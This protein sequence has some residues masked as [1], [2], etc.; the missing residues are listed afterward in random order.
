M[1]HGAPSGQEGETSEPTSVSETS[2]APDN[3]Q[4]VLDYYAAHP[5]FFIFATPADVPG[6]LAWENGSDLPEIGS[7]DAKKGGTW[8]ARIQ[9]FPRTLRLM[10][11]DSNG[12][13]RGYILDDVRMYFGHA[14]PQPG[15]DEFLGYPGLAKEWAVDKDSSTVFVRID[16]DARFNDGEPVTTEDVMFSFFMFRSSYVVSPWL[17]DYY[18]TTFSKVTQYD[19]HTFSLTFPQTKPDMVSKALGWVPM[20][21]HFFKELGEDF[22][23]RYQWKFVPTTGPYV[24]H[25]EDLKKGRSVV[26]RRDD[27]WWAKDKKFWR[28]RYN[29]DALRLVVIRDTPKAFEAF[30]RGDL[31]DTS[32]NLAEYWYDKLPDTDDAVAKGY[33]EKAWFYN[34]RPRPTYGL[35]V[36]SHKPVLDDQNIRLGLQHATNFQQV[37]DK[38]Y[39]GDVT[40]MKSRTDGYGPVSHPTI[41]ARA[42]DVEKAKEYFA[43]AGYTEVG[44]DGVLMNAEGKRLSFTLST[45]YEALKDILAI[46]REEGMKAGV[47][48]RLEVL[49]GTT[50]WKKFQEKKHDIHLAAFGVGY[51]PYPRHFEFLHSYNAYENAFLEDGSVNPDRKV[52]TQTNNNRMV[53]N[54]ELDQLV[55]RY[56]D[57]DD[58]AEKTA[59]GH[60]IMEIEH[61]HASFIPGWVQPFYRRAHW[62]WL[63]HPEGYAFQHSEYENQH[64]EAWIDED[65]KK[66]TKAAM[67]AGETFPAQIN[68]YDQWKEDE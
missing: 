52:R 63:R 48:Y 30:R 43:K 12:S 7:P 35:W 37:I 60:R 68:T 39:R 58:A 19:E 45:G 55:D 47:E 13:F 15:S 41:R 14:H 2:E 46:L 54:Y 29:F 50:G 23:E 26:I 22:V 9:D 4:E 18:S 33:I 25:P 3:T 1:R 40:R 28:Y 6:D 36:N 67:K 66:E 31:E 65:L 5:D 51:E 38:F 59:L 62:R 16:R 11:P 17:N 61:E 8:S 44:E 34:Q 27:N 42:F 53:A 64:Y 21:R 32:L 20:P 49:D 56:R 57:S 24:V 10:G